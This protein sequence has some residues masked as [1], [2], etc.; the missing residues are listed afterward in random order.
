MTTVF[1][2]GL[3]LIG[4]S[5]ARIMQQIDTD[6]TVLGADPNDDT[7]QFLLAQGVIDARTT[8][9]EGSAKA[10]VIILAGPVSVIT[11]QLAALADLPLKPNVVVIDVGSTKRQV[12]AAAKPLQ[13]KGIALW[14]AIR[15]PVPTK[16]GVGPVGSTSLTARCTFWSTVPRGWNSANCFNAYWRPHSYAG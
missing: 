11:K 1:I 9:A 14:A 7:S 8:F 2:S 16:L 10:D 4:S 3:G 13:K 12:M 6:T 15:W 5:L